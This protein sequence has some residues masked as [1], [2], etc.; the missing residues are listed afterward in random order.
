[1]YQLGKG[2]LMVKENM[3]LVTLYVKVEI[4][5]LGDCHVIV[6]VTKYL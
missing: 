3:S 6:N 1:M 4:Y 2:K 5:H